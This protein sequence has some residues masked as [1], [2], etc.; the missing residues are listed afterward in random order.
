MIVVDIYEI[1]RELDFLS[2]LSYYDQHWYISLLS[3]NIILLW[4]FK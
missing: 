1:Y 3:T 4:R 2:N